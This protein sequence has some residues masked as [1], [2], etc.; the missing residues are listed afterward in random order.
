MHSDEEKK[1]S[2]SF[3]EKLADKVIGIFLLFAALIL[4][5]LSVFLTSLFYKSKLP[6]TEVV[7]PEEPG[8]IDEIVEEE[9][10]LSGQTIAE[11]MKS[12][13]KLSTAEYYYTHV[14]SHDSAL[15]LE[16]TN[17]NIP[18]TKNKFVYS[19]DGSITAGVDFT[20][21]DVAV[22]E[23]KKTVT[24]TLPEV[25]VISSEIDEDSFK[26]YDEQNSAF[27]KISVKDVA[28][29]FADMKKDEEAKAREKGLFDNAEKNAKTMIEGFVKSTYDVSGYKVI[30]K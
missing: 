29:S 19:Y 21:I 26:L 9:V 6:K 24:V 11:G 16:G 20:K 8:I 2:D 7:E 4:V 5:G 3:K 15:Q 14:E 18:F 1:M 27:N 30:V 25:E 28:A 23:E 22:D 10:T 17:F 13:G 12:I